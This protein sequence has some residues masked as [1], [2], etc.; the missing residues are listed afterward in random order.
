MIIGN[1]NKQ[2]EVIKGWL[3]GQFLEEGPFKDTN[4]EIFCKKFLKG[5][6]NDKLHIHPTG[7]EYLIIISGKILMRV[8]DEVFEMNDG[9]YI[10]INGGQKDK[11]EKILEDTIMLGVRSPSIPNNKIFLET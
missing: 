3:V 8:N 5:D 10:A 2:R 6:N 7:K 9:D 11:M 1:I 4:M